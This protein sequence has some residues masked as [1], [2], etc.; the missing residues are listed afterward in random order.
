MFI[1]GGDSQK[2]KTTQDSKLS[3]DFPGEIYD[4][5][6]GFWQFLS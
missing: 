1:M 5:Q 3:T 6:M 2:V 4:S